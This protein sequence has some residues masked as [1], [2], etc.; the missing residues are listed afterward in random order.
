[1]KMKKLLLALCL[2]SVLSA[3]AWAANLWQYNSYTQV[4]MDSAK[5]IMDKGSKVLS[6]NTI[7]TIGDSK[8]YC[9][10]V[11]NIDDQTIQIKEMKTISSKLSY[12]SNFWPSSI[13]NG[14]AVV[15]ERAAMANA[16]LAQKEAA[17]KK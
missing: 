9:V 11:Y 6:F 4:D 16:V 1:M 5:V 12:T 8:S 17:H 7:E 10:Y 2:A 3:P 14:S 13:K 15:Q